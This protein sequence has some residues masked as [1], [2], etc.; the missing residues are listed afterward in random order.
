MTMYYFYPHLHE[1]MTISTV[2]AEL[3]DGGLTSGGAQKL[4]KDRPK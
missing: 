3:K 4:A 2:V 1:S